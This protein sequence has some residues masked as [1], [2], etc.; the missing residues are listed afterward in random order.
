MSPILF[1]DLDFNGLIV[2]D[3]RAGHGKE[4]VD[5]I[6]S[7][8]K[9]FVGPEGGFSPQEF[10]AMDKAGVYG[11]SLGKTILRAEVAAVVA[12]AKVLNK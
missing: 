9:L 5:K 2:A 1:K 7:Y 12:I 11:L 8:G 6:E 10:D 3:E 4:I